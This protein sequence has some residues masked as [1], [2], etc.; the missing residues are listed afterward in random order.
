[1]KLIVFVICFTALGALASSSYSQATK[2]SLNINNTSIKEVLLEIEN[3]S[4]FYFLYNN[5]LIDVE[6]KVDV[7]VKEKKITAILDI[8]FEGQE[9]NFSIM[10]RQIVISPK[11][12]NNPNPS[13]QP[14]ITGEVTDEFGEPMPGVTVLIKGTTTGA[15]TDINGNYS[16]AA[17]S[18]DVLTFSFIGTGT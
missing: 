12:I 1:M 11:D 7:E 18:D 17:T 14:Q 9:V 6:K 13:A 8:L 15:I 2:L 3:K 5:D 16:I 4:D 10:D